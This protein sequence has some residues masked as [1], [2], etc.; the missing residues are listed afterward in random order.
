[1]DYTHWRQISHNSAAT[2]SSAVLVRVR[3][4]VRTRFAQS[5]PSR[6]AEKQART[7][8]MYSHALCARINYP[9]FTVTLARLCEWADMHMLLERT[10]IHRGHIYVEIIRFHIS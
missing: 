5:L 4:C 3:V 6:F 7:G 1:M 9:Q 8:S 2:Q 10:H